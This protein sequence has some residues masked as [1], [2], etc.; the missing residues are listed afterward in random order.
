MGHDV[1]FGS[2]AKI[3]SPNFCIM[4]NHVHVGS[5]FRCDVDLEVLGDVLISSDV[6]FVG[7][8]HRFEADVHPELK[9]SESSDGGQL[10]VA[11]YPH[12]PVFWGG[13]LPSCRVV[14]EG[15]NLIGHGVIFVGSLTV[16][17]GAIIGAGSVVTKNVPAGMIYAG[18]PARPLRMR[19]GV[20]T[21]WPFQAS[22][23]P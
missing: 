16:G 4:G 12:V 7:N 15:D 19:R 2:G 13:R 22:P 20:P 11:T 3:L 5:G 21:T 14:L 8:D 17:K 1:E 23:K 10:P 9:S 6:S 18:V